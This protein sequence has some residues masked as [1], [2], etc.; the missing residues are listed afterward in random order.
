M[1]EQKDRT[2]VPDD[3]IRLLNSLTTAI[4]PHSSLTFANSCFQSLTLN[5]SFNAKWIIPILTWTFLH[6]FGLNPLA[7]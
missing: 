2:W 7:F 4:R 3:V 6:N 5:L 1:A